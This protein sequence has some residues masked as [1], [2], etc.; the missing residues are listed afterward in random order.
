MCGRFL[1][2]RNRNQITPKSKCI[3]IPNAKLA[4]KLTLTCIIFLLIAAFSGSAAEIYDSMAKCAAI[5]DDNAARLKCFDDLAKK[6][7]AAKE[8][9]NLKP[10][11]KKDAAVIVEKAA[12]K[13]PA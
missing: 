11:E 4:C 3:K 9:V 5:K 10:V 7:N 12:A 8:S 2:Q 13:G 1:Q 6:Q